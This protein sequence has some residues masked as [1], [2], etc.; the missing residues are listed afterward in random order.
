[1]AE[2][3]RRAAILLVLLAS[4]AAAQ[5]ALPG[6][7]LKGHDGVVWAVAVSPDGKV[8]ASGGRD[9]TIRLRELPSMKELGTLKGH[10][11]DVR[12]VAFRPDGRVLASGG[13]G[14]DN[15]LWDLKTGKDLAT[16]QGRERGGSSCVIFSPDGKTLATGSAQLDLWDVSAVK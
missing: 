12:S 15:K 9:K 14:M 3:A 4:P 2:L 13:T 7:S 5:E 11:S 16:F 8:M 1:M 10:T 6:K